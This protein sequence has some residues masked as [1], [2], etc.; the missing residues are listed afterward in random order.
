[1]PSS[2]ITFA[3]VERQPGNIP[4]PPDAETRI[5]IVK[6][7]EWIVEKLNCGFEW[8]FQAWEAHLRK[9]YLAKD[10]PLTVVRGTPGEKI[11]LTAD[12]LEKA[13]TYAKTMAGTAGGGST[14]SLFNRHSGS[15]SSSKEIPGAGTGGR[16]AMLAQTGGSSSTEGCEKEKQPSAGGKY[17]VD[18]RDHVH[19]HSGREGRDQLSSKRFLI[20]SKTKT[21]VKEDTSSPSASSESE[22][23]SSSSSD[24]SSDSESLSSSSS[25]SS[26]SVRIKRQTNRLKIKRN[27]NKREETRKTDR[28]RQK[29]TIASEKNAKKFRER[30]PKR[31]P[32]RDKD[33]DDRRYDQ[34]HRKVSGRTD[35]G[36]NRLRR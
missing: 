11:Q 36:P 5:K 1:M 35:K 25:S 27:Y 19:D 16:Q 17:T 7:G 21:R 18:K 10:Y 14:S 23:S 4:S 2:S 34:R 12:V 13:M 31:K 22:A 26:S 8:E 3:A 15:S 20:G 30:S 9:E 29:G 33:R 6:V 28:G 32:L 24:T